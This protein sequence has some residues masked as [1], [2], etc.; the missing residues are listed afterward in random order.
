MTF[1]IDCTQEEW[2]ELYEE[3]DTHMDLLIKGLATVEPDW[4]DPEVCAHWD[5]KAQEADRELPYQPW[6][7]DIDPIEF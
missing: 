4:D 6:D 1:R 7:H 5:K 3:E 2:D